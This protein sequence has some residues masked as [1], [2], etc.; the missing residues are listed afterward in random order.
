MRAVLVC[1]ALST[2]AHAW[3]ATIGEICTLNHDTETA[4]IFLT[5]DPERPYYTIT[6]TLKTDRWTRAPWFAMRF[7]GRNPIEISTARHEV[8]PDATALTAAFITTRGQCQ[9]GK[10]NDKK[11]VSL[12][13]CR[14]GFIFCHPHAYY[15]HRHQQKYLFSFTKSE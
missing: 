6:L 5:Y 14:P 8:S 10:T 1:L 3:E 15:D 2:P 13:L 12:S 4:N 11:K 7:D 9:K